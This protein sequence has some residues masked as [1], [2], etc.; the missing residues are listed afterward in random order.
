MCVGI[1]HELD[2]MAVSSYQGGV[3]STGVVNDMGRPEA[4][5]P[6][7]TCWTMPPTHSAKQHVAQNWANQSPVDK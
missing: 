7:R 5:L 3:Q 1:E 6:A 4:T 2:F